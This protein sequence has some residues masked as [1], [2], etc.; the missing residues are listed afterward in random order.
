[1][2]SFLKKYLINNVVLV[3]GIQQSDQVIHTYV[4]IHLQVLFLFRLLENAEHSSFALQQGL[5]G[6]LF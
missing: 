5:L 2:E 1:M 4:S 3:S 6:Y